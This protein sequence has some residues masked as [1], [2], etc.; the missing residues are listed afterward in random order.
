MH[1]WRLVLA[2]LLCAFATSSWG[3]AFPDRP[4]RIIV[5]FTSGTAA[6]IVARQLAVKLTDALGKQVVVENRDGASGTIGAGLAA[7]VP[8]PHECGGE[9]ARRAG[10]GERRLT[11]D[12]IS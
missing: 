8:R 5:A 12:V 2:A 1:D 7:V 4:L 3:Q 9:V 11:S 10:E 6:D